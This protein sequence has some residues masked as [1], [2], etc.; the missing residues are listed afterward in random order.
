MA[1]RQRMWA[2]INEAGEIVDLMRVRPHLSGPTGTRTAEVVVYEGDPQSELAAERS[3]HAAEVARY[4]AALNT[5]PCVCKRLLITTC[6]QCGGRLEAVTYPSDSMLN[7]DQFDSVRAGDWYCTSCKGVEA[8][9]GYKYWWNSDL[10]KSNQQ[11]PRC[12]ALAA[13]PTAAAQAVEAMRE[14]F[15]HLLDEIDAV[16]TQCEGEILGE[17][18]SLSDAYRGARA[19]LAAW[20]EATRG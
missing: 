15:D 19:A 17:C 10:V 14:K 3:A 16:N 9:S 4:R 1:V 11:C 7:R 5:L 8:R 13:P 12:A 20:K 18:P 2:N 6:P